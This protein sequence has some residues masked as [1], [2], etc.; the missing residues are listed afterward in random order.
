MLGVMQK[1]KIHLFEVPVYRL[2]EEEYSQQQNE[3]VKM[4]VSDYNH[5]ELFFQ[6][7]KTK[8]NNEAKQKLSEASFWRKEF[9]GGWRYNEI[10]G[11]IRIYKYGIQIRAEYWQTDAKRIVKTRKRKFIIKNRKLV[12]E[13]RIKDND[14]NEAVSLCIESCKKQLN[15]RHLD[16]ETYELIFQHVNWNDVLKCV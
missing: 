16:L 8:G 10:I 4:H 14:M 5:D 2:P 7:I 11:Y 3:Y 15:G 6:A 9:G 12:P 1:M 13:I